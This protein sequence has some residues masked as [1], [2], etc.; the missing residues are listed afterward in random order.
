MSEMNKSKKNKNMEKNIV[1]KKNKPDV[2]KI[3][4]YGLGTVIVLVCAIIIFCD[5]FM[6]FVIT[7][8][9]KSVCH[10]VFK[11]INPYFCRKKQR[12]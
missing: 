9:E 11:A 7:Y 12:L 10:F 6:L 3:I 5:F 4:A 1:I 2:Y 8:D